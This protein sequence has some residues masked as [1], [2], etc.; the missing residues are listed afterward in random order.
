MTIVDFHNHYYPPEYIKELQ[1]GSNEFTVTFDD[2]DNPV[3]HSPGDINVVV[4]GHRDIEVRQQVLDDIGVHKQVITFTAP[5][6]VVETPERSVALAQLVNDCLAKI[7]DE[8]SSHFT[9]LATLPLNDPDASVKELERAMTDLGFKGVMVYS[10][11]NGVA[12]SDR[13]YWPLYERASDLNA[14]IYIHPTYP[15]GVEAM[16]DYWLMPLVGF[17]LDTTLAT[18]SLVFS[19]T[20]ERFPGI[21][22]VLAH[23]GG[24][25][26]YLAER[27][28]RGYY[29]FE[30]CREHISRP[31]TE[32]LKD[33]YY[34]TVNFDP[35][36]LKLA[37]DF[38]GADHILA[39]SDYP[40]QIGS[41][42]Q[43]VASLNK[44]DVNDED[45]AKIMGGNASRL[46]SL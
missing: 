35:N 9:S 8:R 43:M 42:E 40:H 22:W 20:V 4:P 29:A 18:A 16:T 44:L 31:P 28:D 13:R 15:V 5:G 1:A 6:T 39:G 2:D 23:L 11:V 3:L 38:A 36:A 14:V 27:L 33:F 7:V 10:N 46:L 12:L 34:D 21:R 25:I 45:R 17:L 24:A 19:G 37:I 32:F 26:P 41:L 30:S